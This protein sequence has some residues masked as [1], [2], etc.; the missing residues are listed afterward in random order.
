ME[1]KGSS[2]KTLLLYW[3]FSTRVLG[4]GEALIQVVSGRRLYADNAV[5]ALDPGK[6]WQSPKGRNSRACIVGVGPDQ[7]YT[8]IAATRPE[9]AFI[10]DI[11]SQNMLQHLL[12]KSI[13]ELAV[14]RVEFLARL[15]S[16]SCPDR[17]R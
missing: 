16:R 15:F 2:G 11:R 7:N 14:D 8:Y 17:P 5:L 10:V 1:L 13:F 4:A 9:L 6:V 3:T 12:Y